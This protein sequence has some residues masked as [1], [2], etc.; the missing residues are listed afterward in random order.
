MINPPNEQP[1]HS[2]P[3]NPYAPAGGNMPGPVDFSNIANVPGPDP[4]L[5]PHN[6]VGPQFSL[7]EPNVPPAGG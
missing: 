7:P 5:N 3:P 4:S 2:Q 6:S 1:S